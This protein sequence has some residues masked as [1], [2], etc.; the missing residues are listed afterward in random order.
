M[1]LIKNAEIFSPESEG[2][3]DVLIAGGRIVAIDTSLS[4]NIPELEVVD[5]SGLKLVPGFI[6]Q[7]VHLIGGGGEGG[8]HTRT[9]EFRLSSAIRAGVTTIVG[10]LGTDGYTRSI[11]SLVAKTK[12]LKNEGL[13][14]FCLTGSYKYPPNTLTGSVDRD[15]AFI[16]EIIGCKLAIADYRCSNP[17]RQ[18]IIRLAS[19]IRMAS[20]VAGK[21]GVLHM[22]VGAGKE[23]IA[24]ILD[25]VKSSNIP[26]RH[27]RPTHMENH[28][29]QAIEFTK[30]GGY[31]D[32]TADPGDVDALY[33]LICKADAERLTMSS[34]SNGSIPKWNEKHELIG[35]RIANMDTLFGTI[36]LLIKKKGLPPDKALSLVTSNVA[37]AL[38]LY[39]Q[40]GAVALGSDADLVLLD[41]D[42]KIHSVFAKGR[43]MMRNKEVLVKGVFE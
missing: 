25:I 32:I 13:S 43:A 8:M 40:K 41:S 29:Q 15:I 24:K 26:V 23:G 39:P 21:P 27:F 16:D 9:P 17:T 38:N 3:K 18:E 37:K 22:H 20:L 36:R 4:P 30:L 10:L 6:D 35:I 12:A 33:D 19:D 14:V 1:Y 28:P 31:V 34:D 2:L 7:H 11:E 42:F 5:A